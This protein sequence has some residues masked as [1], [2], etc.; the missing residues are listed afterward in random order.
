MSTG[1]TTLHNLST[2]KGSLFV[3]H[4]D[5]SQTMVS[6]VT[7]GIVAKPLMSGVHQDGFIMSQFMV[8]KLLN[9]DQ[10]FY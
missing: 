6:L 4:I 2:T 1:Y 5:I 3:C 7:H 10:Y 8:E 9:I